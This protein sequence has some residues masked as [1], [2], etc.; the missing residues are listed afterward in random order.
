MDPVTVG[1][2]ARESRT[3]LIVGAGTAGLLHALT[4]KAHGVRIAAIFDPDGDKARS[5]A[6]LV[7]G[8]AVDAPTAKD[9]EAA[10]IVVIGSPPRVHA[11]QCAELSRPDRTLV[12]EKPIATT[13]AE[14][15]GLA[16]LPNA[17]AVLQWRVGRGLVAVRRAV[18]AGLLGPVPSVAVD[19]A[20]QRDALYFA[21]EGRDSLSRWGAGPLLS[22]GIHAVDAALHAL[23]AVAAR[24]VVATMARRPG[25]DLERAAALAVETDRG[26]IVSL[27]FPVEAAP[28]EVRFAFAGGGVTLTLAGSEQDPTGADLSIESTDAALAQK[29]AELER[30]APGGRSAPLLVPLYA[31]ILK[32]S[33]SLEPPT[34]SSAQLAHRVMFEAYAAD[35]QR[36]PSS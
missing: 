16:A 30:V 18:A 35:E 12:V 5:L 8:M 7:G 13:V 27:R 22:I 36:T 26:A 3:A 17:F 14:L 19:C 29:L 24:R 11:A 6:E 32:P 28:D 21:K 33:A 4:L 20:L 2:N 15:D 10:S 34:L 9:A 23:G 25:S 31:A 1:P